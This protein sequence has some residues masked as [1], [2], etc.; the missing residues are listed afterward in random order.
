MD[1]LIRGISD[2]AV[3]RLDSEAAELGLSRNEYL[4]RKI[5]DTVEPKSRRKITADDWARTARIHADLSDEEVMRSAW[6]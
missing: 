4:R 3:K 5:E 1:I 2:A 6:H